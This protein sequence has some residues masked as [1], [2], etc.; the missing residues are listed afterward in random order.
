M[1]APDPVVDS[2]SKFEFPIEGESETVA[3]LKVISQSVGVSGVA[4]SRRQP[5]AQRC[6]AVA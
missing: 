4:T 2:H 6:I 3:P 5:Q 1:A